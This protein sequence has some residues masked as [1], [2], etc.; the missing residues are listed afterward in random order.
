MSK[1]TG[2][3]GEVTASISPGVTVAGIDLDRFER[4]VILGDAGFDTINDGGSDDIIVGG[5]DFSPDLRSARRSC[6][7]RSL[8]GHECHSR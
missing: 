6:D 2:Q 4:I 5:P 3:P 8:G 7:C 1:P